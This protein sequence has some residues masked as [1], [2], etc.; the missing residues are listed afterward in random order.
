[1]YISREN[2]QNVW[3]NLRKGQEEVIQFFFGINKNGLSAHDKMFTGTEYIFYSKR[4]RGGLDTCSTLIEWC[5]ISE[6]ELSLG[7]KERGLSSWGWWLLW[8]VWLSLLLLLDTLAVA[9]DPAV[10]DKGWR[11]TIAWISWAVYPKR[12]CRSHTKRYTYL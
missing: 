6:E 5:P 8:L 7:A 12:P 10:A 3:R 2:L 4:W 1:M 9:A 11:S